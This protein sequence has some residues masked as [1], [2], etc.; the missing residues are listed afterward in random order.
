M[1]DVYILELIFKEKDGH[2][3]Y[4]Y[5]E[6]DM[7]FPIEHPTHRCLM[8]LSAAKAKRTKILKEFKRGRF[9]GLVD[10]K[11]KPVTLKIGNEVE[12]EW[13]RSILTGGY[14]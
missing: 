12:K 1:D 14:R 9:A 7:Y 8:E 10:I 3:K 6:H 11:I 13:P 5:F 4:V 2:E